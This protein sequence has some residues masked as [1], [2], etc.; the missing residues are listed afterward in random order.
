MYYIYRSEEKNSSVI[1]IEG[2]L[3]SVDKMIE[4]IPE[5]DYFHRKEPFAE[6]YIYSVKNDQG[7]IIDLAKLE[8]IS[9]DCLKVFQKF[10]SIYKIKFRNYSLYIEMQL[11]EYGL[12]T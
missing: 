10:K 2:R 7:I 9:E 6:N 11:N 1:H 4:L 12:L 3:D 5:F 8:F